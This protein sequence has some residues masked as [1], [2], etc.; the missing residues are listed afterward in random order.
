MITLLVEHFSDD[1]AQDWQGELNSLMDL[2]TSIFK[3]RKAKPVP[4][5]RP[6]H[7]NGSI[8]LW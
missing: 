4:K 7:E 6:D 1:P 3:E 5:N 8:Y 2:V